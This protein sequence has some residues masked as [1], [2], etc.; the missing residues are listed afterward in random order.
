MTVLLIMVGAVIV[1]GGAG[2]IYSRFIARKIGEDPGRSTPALRKA[3]GRDFVPT[4]TPVVFAHHF[5]SIAGAGP[6]VGPVVAFVYGWLPA[7]L[8]V[9]FG[10]VF[11][12]AVHDYLATYMATR[13]GGQSM[14]TIVRRM[15]GKGAFVAMTI[16]LVVILAL[17]CATFLNL[18]ASALTSMLPFDRLELERDQQLFRVVTTGGT[19]KVVIG[20][21]ASMSVSS[22]PRCG[23]SSRCRRR[24]PPGSASRIDRRPSDKRA[25]A[26]RRSTKR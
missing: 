7:V 3:D 20:G 26:P 13:E 14:A 12:G 10:G 6:I 21:I 24:S 9:V 23:R 17:V 15:L 8:W 5:A 19:D 4:P 16:F 2:Q 25:S 18:S 1:L 11:I 22:P